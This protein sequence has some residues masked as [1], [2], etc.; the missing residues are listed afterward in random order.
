VVF[1][2]LSEVRILSG[3]V[4]GV[5]Y[6]AIT[7]GNAALGIPSAFNVQATAS[8]PIPI[9]ATT[10]T[11][12]TFPFATRRAD[13]RFVGYANGDRVNPVFDLPVTGSGTATVTL[14]LDDVLNGKPIFSGTQITWAFDGAAS[15]TPEPASML[16]LGTG[17]GAVLVARR[18]AAGAASRRRRGAPPPALVLIGSCGH[19]EADPRALYTVS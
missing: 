18:R 6:P 19:T 16:L 11:Q 15:P 12:L 14:H 8:T 7:L 3:T 5:S 2:A 10:G 17:I 4:D 1:F 13:S 9:D